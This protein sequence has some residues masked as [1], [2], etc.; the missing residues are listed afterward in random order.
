MALESRRHAE[1]VAVA[2][3]VAAQDPR[4]TW[5]LRIDKNGFHRV[6][7]ESRRLFQDVIGKTSHSNHRFLACVDS[8][9]I[10]CFAMGVTRAHVSTEATESCLSR[11]PITVR[12]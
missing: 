9:G 4:D 11:I 2:T 8:C 6:H 10:V 7:I 1:C 12:N 5:Y 3:S